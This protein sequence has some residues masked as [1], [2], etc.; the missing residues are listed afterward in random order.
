MKLYY[1]YDLEI[2]QIEE[3]TLNSITGNGSTLNLKFFA[4]LKDAEENLIERR[5]EFCEKIRGYFHEDERKERNLE[6]L[7]GFFKEI[8]SKPDFSEKMPLR[9]VRRIDGRS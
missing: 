6:I 9:L 1:I 4:D 2:K 7:K 8:D 3:E 5:I